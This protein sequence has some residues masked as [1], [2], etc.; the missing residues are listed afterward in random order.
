MA[1]DNKPIKK[2][3]P[4]ASQNPRDEKDVHEPSKSHRARGG[5]RIGTGR[6]RLGHRGRGRSAPNSSSRP[7]EISEDFD[8]PPESR[9]YRGR[10]GRS[11]PFRSFRGGGRRGGRGPRGGRGGRG[12]GRRYVAED[13]DDDES[14]ISST[15]AAAEA[16]GP[17]PGAPECLL[18]AS[19][20]EHYALVKCIHS[21]EICGKCVVNMRKFQSVDSKGK[22]LQCPFCKNSWNRIVLSGDPDATYEMVEGA[23]LMER[24]PDSDLTCFAKNGKKTRFRFIEQLSSHLEQK[25]NLFLCMACI[26]ARKQSIEDATLYTHNALMKHF[27]NGTPAMG[28]EPAIAPHPFCQFCKVPYFSKDD[29]FVHMESDHYQCTFCNRPNNLNRIYFRTRRALRNHYSESHFL[30]SEC[31]GEEFDAVFS[32]EVELKKHMLSFHRDGR[33]QK[34]S[35]RERTITF[36]PPSGGGIYAGSSRGRGRGGGRRRDKD[37]AYLSLESDDEDQDHSQAERVREEQRRKLEARYRAVNEARRRASVSP[38]ADT[39]ASSDAASKFGRSRSVPESMAS[40]ASGKRTSK[41]TEEAFPVLGGGPTYISGNASYRRRPDAGIEAFPA[42]P[43]GR[44]EKK[45]KSRSRSKKKAVENPPIHSVDTKPSESKPTAHSTRSVTIPGM[46]LACPREKIKEVNAKFMA[47]IKGQLGQTA[48]KEIRRATRGFM[49]DDAPA[50]HFLETFYQFSNDE[51][52]LIPFISLVASRSPQKA[53]L[54]FLLTNKGKSKPSPDKKISDSK[55]IIVSGEAKGK[56]GRKGLGGARKARRFITLP[57]SSHFR[58]LLSSF[59]TYRNLSSFSKSQPHSSLETPLKGLGGWGRVKDRPP[60]AS[61][62]KAKDSYSSGEKVFAI[63]PPEGLWYHASIDSPGQAGKAIVRY[64]GYAEL[65]EL[66]L[67]RIR[68]NPLQAMGVAK[69]EIQPSKREKKKG[70]SKLQRAQPDQKLN[71]KSDPEWAREGLVDAQVVRVQIGD[72]TTTKAAAVNLVVLSEIHS[73]CEKYLELKGITTPAA[74]RREV[75]SGKRTGLIQLA[76]RVRFALKDPKILSIFGDLRSQGFKEPSYKYF[77]QLNNI[78]ASEQGVGYRV[79][80]FSQMLLL[81]AI[82]DAKILSNVV[83][84]KALDSYWREHSAPRQEGK[85]N[86]KKKKKTKRVMLL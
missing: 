57:I 43:V 47:D 56:R 79:V 62:G 27:R 69:A 5:R 25:H 28:D 49:C 17:L 29:L 13:G 84:A 83:G 31:K 12:R 35:K 70:S 66:S 14:I 37:T 85:P 55:D 59:M 18:C 78:M 16:P 67:T 7:L 61:A 6:G 72:L 48:Y 76:K 1:T 3:V 68:P 32:N 10:R 58:C 63:Y 33:H 26:G 34:L 50:S 42:L 86:K 41:N 19:P 4:R 23:K 73:Q 22:P 60:P 82:G 65:Q 71:P 81:R 53:R 64:D 38:H 51:S 80:Q 36:G 24:K 21:G 54:L 52:I 74:I 11:T 77:N 39:A 75:T 20:I 44:K 45:K 9:G 46:P 40:V 15:T 2:W 30:C 8:P